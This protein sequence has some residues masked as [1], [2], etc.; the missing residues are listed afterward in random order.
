MFEKSAKSS[1]QLDDE[2]LHPFVLQVSIKRAYDLLLEK[3]KETGYLDIIEDRDY[4]E[5]YIQRSEE[6]EVTYYLV[7][8]KN[9]N[10]RIV[11]LIYTPNK[12]G[13]AKKILRN[14]IEEHKKDFDKYLCRHAVH[15]NKE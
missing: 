11:M 15:D 13:K 5:I 14:L 7:D 10:T 12:R 1:F 3:V 8:E 2:S 4:W 9:G 6:L